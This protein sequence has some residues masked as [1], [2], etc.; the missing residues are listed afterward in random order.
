MKEIVFTKHILEDSYIRIPK[1]RQ[2]SE[3]DIKRFYEWLFS[4]LYNSSDYKWF[5]VKIYSANNGT[6]KIVAGKHKFVYQESDDEI[7]LITYAKKTEANYAEGKLLEEIRFL[8]R[9]PHDYYGT[10]K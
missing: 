5:P 7:K 8:N 9:M 6:N 1:H 4:R 2:E 3:D 10:N